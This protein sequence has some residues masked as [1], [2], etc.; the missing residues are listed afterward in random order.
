M[1]AL[2]ET[3]FGAGAAR[4]S[5]SKRDDEEIDAFVERCTQEEGGEVRYSTTTGK[6][7]YCVNTTE[8]KQCEAN[9]G[10]DWYFSESDGKCEEGCFLTTACVSHAGLDDRCFELQALREFRDGVLAHLPSG[11][12]DIA[13]YYAKAPA[14]VAK[15][16]AAPQPAREFARLYA[17]YI[18]P[19]ALAA[20]LGLGEL[21][22]RIYTRMMT[23]LSARFGTAWA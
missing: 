3:L 22:R 2:S 23:D 14:I 4:A 11:R 6:P 15:M 1:V 10:K 5:T 18:F 21:T 20:R 16:L 7:D 19:S 12:A 8:D 9:N 17:L 13:S